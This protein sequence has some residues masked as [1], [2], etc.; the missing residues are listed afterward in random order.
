MFCQPQVC[1]ECPGKT[2]RTLTRWDT[3]HTRAHHTWNVECR[4]H[5]LSFHA[6]QCSIGGL[7]GVGIEVVSVTVRTPCSGDD[8]DVFPYEKMFVLRLWRPYAIHSTFY[9]L[10]L[11]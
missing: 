10:L 4:L 3:H 11:N 6:S 1:G 7:I 2:G 8:V 5:L 9:Y